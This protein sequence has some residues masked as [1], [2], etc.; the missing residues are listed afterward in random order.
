M[1]MHCVL[2]ATLALAFGGVIQASAAAPDA[3]STS[4]PAKSAAA[5]ATAAQNSKADQAKYVA[6]YQLMTP[7]ERKAFRE[8]MRSLK[9]PKER[10]ALRLEHRKLMEKRAAERGEKLRPM[11]TREQVQAR[12]AAA[13][14]NTQPQQK[15]DPASADQHPAH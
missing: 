13:K 1:R 3:S 15:K 2:I 8:K 7:Q 9:T 14:H 10:E 4:V 6:P 5:P 12:A 11:P